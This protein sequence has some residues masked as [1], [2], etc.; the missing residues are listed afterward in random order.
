MSWAKVKTR[1][2]MQCSEQ[3]CPKL[4]KAMLGPPAKHL[5]CLQLCRGCGKCDLRAQSCSCGGGQTMAWRCSNCSHMDW[6]NH[7]QKKCNIALWL[8][9]F[10]FPHLLEVGRSIV[11]PKYAINYCNFQGSHRASI[12][13]GPAI[14]STKCK[15]FSDTPETSDLDIELQILQR[16]QVVNL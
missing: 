8:C 10:L 2:H 11:E 1:L 15:T 7:L 16:L 3:R 13:T 14:Q 4:A 9:T 12:M 5:A 6:G